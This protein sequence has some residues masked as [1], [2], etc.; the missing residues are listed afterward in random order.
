MVREP[1]RVPRDT[2]G[3][4]GDRLI[5]K[6]VITAGLQGLSLAL[7]FAL[8]LVLARLLGKDGYGSYVFAVAWAGVLTTPAILGLDRFL[9]RGIAVYEVG[10]DWSLARGL[11]ERTA[12]TV[13]L[14]SLVISTVGCLVGLLWMSPSTKGPF[15][16]AMALIPLTALT[17]LR[18]AAMQAIGRVIEG[19]FPE[20]LIRPVLILALVVALGLFGSLTPMIAVGANVAG[21]G[22]AAVV[23]ALMLRRALPRIIR[24]AG[25]AYETRNWL[26]ASLPM[27]L[28]G[29]VW[30]AN[31]YLATL[32]V[33]VLAGA[34]SAGVYAVAERGSSLI[35]M[36]LLAGNMALGPVVA[37]LYAKGDRA[38]LERESTRVARATFALSL[39][40]ALILVLFPQLYLGL[41]GEGFSSGATALVILVAGQVFNAAAGP[42]GNV[43]MMTRHEIAAA[44]GVAVGL[45]ANVV[46]GVV[47]VPSIGVTGGAIA[48]TASLVLWN[49]LLV[50]FARRHVAV[51]VTAL[52]ALD[53]WSGVA[54]TG[55]S[56]SRTL[57]VG[58]R[59]D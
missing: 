49:T 40:V 13:L 5:S 53:I 47:L 46:L 19:Q 6:A 43:L 16:L 36:M 18:Q 42:A 1:G 58:A 23:G 38:G 50:L 39:P 7:G 45:A 37:R 22:G 48:F 14:T 33:G 32:I 20:Y 2:T 25:S 44:G 59:D 27:M 54:P 31:Y 35:V 56:Q 21:V 11:L 41:F 24:S 55:E 57:P 34:A 30:T 12:H 3:V 51:N 4:A 17:L 9:V 8:A 52:R 10:R 15:C 26:R 29:G 28:T